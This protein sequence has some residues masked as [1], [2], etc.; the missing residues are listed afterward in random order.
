MRIRNKGKFR[1]K[2]RYADFSHGNELFRVG[3]FIGI[4]KLD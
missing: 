4:K 1:V 3:K 2:T